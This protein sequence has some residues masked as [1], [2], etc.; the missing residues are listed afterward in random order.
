MFFRKKNSTIITMVKINIRSLV[1]G[2]ITF[3]VFSTLVSCGDNQAGK[4]GTTFL[5]KI[6]SAIVSEAPDEYTP[7]STLLVLPANPAPGEG[8]RILATGGRNIRKVKIIVSGPSGKLESLE[9]KTGDE[10]PFWRIDAYAGSPAGTYKASLIEENKEVGNLEFEIAPRKVIPQKG[11]VWKTTRG[12]D[13]GMETIYS[14]WINALFQGSNEQ[15]SWSALHE[16]T[17][18][19]EHNFLYNYLSIG[20]DDPE[21]KNKVIMEPDCADN[22]FFLRAYFA[23][24]LGLP[25][26]YHVCDRGYVGHNPQTGKWITNETSSSKTNPVL[27]F[28]SFLRLIMDGVHSGTAR[29]ALDNENSDY[30]P[31]TLDRAGLR[32]G[33]VYADPYGHTL[34]LVSWIPQTN[35]H[36]GRLLSVD[37]QPDNTIAIKQFWKGNFLFNTSEVVGE[38]GFKAFRPIS[39]ENG[40]LSLV[41]NE[42]LNVSAGFAPFSLQQ[43]KMK[44]EAFYLAMERLINPEPLDPEDALTGLIE[45]L[46]EQLLVRVK[47]VANGEAYLKS[48]PGIVIPMPSNAN[49]IFQAG[50]QWED[51]STPNR[52]LRLLI[53]MDAVLGFP[54]RVVGS[55]EDFKIS[56]SGSPENIK[57]KLQ[58]LLD[59]KTSELTIS[60]TRS[61]GSSQEL[62]LAEILKRRDAFEMAYNPNDGIEIRWGAPENSDERSTCR[63]QAPS[64]QQKTMQSVRKWFTRR[65]HPPT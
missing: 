36:P 3:L 55:P 19:K 63:R 50:G 42:A 14:A 37:A 16:V 54:D 46:H 31:V 49:G 8:F 56:R 47:S 15:A 4:K 53:A 28:N 17:Q 65:L 33:I 51:F 18:N 40:R 5:E 57:M 11:V 13:S 39:F 59:K 44:S 32:P 58:S 27:A 1:I 38:P 25:F 26:G 48:H 60:Y 6:E 21:G 20:E 22:P 29:T 61:D 45:A 52:D 24:K 12:W 10:L 62:S 41:Q 7:V 64:N 30:Y 43:R 35:D 34:I 2:S 9:T 23:W